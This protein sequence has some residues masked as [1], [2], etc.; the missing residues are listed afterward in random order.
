MKC[1]KEKTI[2]LLLGLLFLSIPATVYAVKPKLDSVILQLKWSHNFQFAGYYMAKEKGYYRDV[3]LDVNFV[4]GNANT[5]VVQEVVEHRANFGIGNSGLVLDR[6]SGQP[7]VVLGVIFQHSAYVLLMHKDKPLQS[8]HDIAGKKVLL[9]SDSEELLA[10]LNQEKIPLNSIDIIEHSYNF[11]A[12]IDHR[13][14]AI[15]AYSINEPFML[16]KLKIPYE[17]YSP[18]SVDIDFY[19]D[20]LFT[21]QS[22]IDDY[23]KR[24]KAFREASFKGWQYAMN[25]IEETVQ[26]IKRDYTQNMSVEELNYTA[27]AMLPLILPNLMEAGYMIEGRWRHIAQTYAD[28][29]MLPN[30]SSDQSLKE[31]LYTPTP[32]WDLRLINSAGVTLL[33]L[34]ISGIALRFF[35][36]NKQFRKLLHVQYQQNNL[37]AVISVMAHQ[38]KQPLNQLGVLMMTIEVLLARQS[39]FENNKK[40]SEIVSKMHDILAN[41]AKTVDIFQSFLFVSSKIGYFSPAKLIYNTL[42]LVNHDFTM[43]Q[44]TIVCDL[45]N[46]FAI[47]GDVS[48]FSHALLSILVNSKDA[49][50][51]NHTEHRSIHI[52]LFQEDTKTNLIISD[53]AGGIKIKP[54]RKIFNFGVS[55]KQNTESGLG[56]YVTK[57]IIEK[58][59]GKIS[60]EN[61]NEG[62]VFKIELPLLKI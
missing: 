4:E 60:A 1:K 15:S 56:L 52:G 49:F 55:C 9:E 34:V 14:D 24:V 36:L 29:G 21:S 42:Q 20:N 22:E 7:I 37:S 53:N 46:D 2:I 19:G 28:L 59:G 39:E 62:A 58:M 27:Q 8:I 31:F 11:Q 40:I 5:N 30:Y 18:R 44:I 45:K 25:N 17:M 10:Y 35:R 16:D 43:N 57:Q 32:T 12:F 50:L 61:N 33:L 54:I 41:M 38:W 3:G 26:L 13:I 47:Q 51:R 48:E 6:N 23:P